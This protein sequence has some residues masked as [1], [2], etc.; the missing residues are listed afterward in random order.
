MGIAAKKRTAKKEKNGITR[1]VTGEGITVRSKNGKVKFG[2]NPL[3]REVQQLEL[4]S[5][6]AF[7]PIID[8]TSKEV[9][10]FDKRSL[11]VERAEKSPK[12]SENC[13]FIYINPST[14]GNGR[15]LMYYE[16][17]RRMV[18]EHFGNTE[19]LVATVSPYG[20]E[21]EKRMVAVYRTN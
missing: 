11:E 8:L 6:E 18:N 4:E 9:Q 1:C 3:N 16:C 15:V 2:Y 7:T 13:L 10:I 20:D 5:E 12:S 14:E 21:A 17:L 19:N